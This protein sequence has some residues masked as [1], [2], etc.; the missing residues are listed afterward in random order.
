M[1][2]VE[3]VM[4]AAFALLADTATH[5]LVRKLSWDIHQKYRTGIDACRPT[6]PS[7]SPL[8]ST[9]WIRLRIT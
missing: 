5:N 9:T 8:T 3:E 4:K 6:S 1:R 7:N 2:K